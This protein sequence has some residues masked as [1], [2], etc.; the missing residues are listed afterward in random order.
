MKYILQKWYLSGYYETYEVILY[1]DFTLETFHDNSG[2]SKDRNR[3]T[4]TIEEFIE[5]K[6]YRLANSC[7]SDKELDEMIIY[8]KKTIENKKKW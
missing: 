4:Y 2:K 7:L 6:P 8:L 3:E 5:T 1:H